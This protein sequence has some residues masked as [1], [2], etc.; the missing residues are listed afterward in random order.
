M[1]DK[2]VS[3]QDAQAH[4]QDLL[5]F[6]RQGH[7]VLIAEGDDVFARIAP[8]A[9]R[10]RILGLSRGLIKMSDDFDDPLPDSFWFGEE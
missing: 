9:R 5:E 6:V 3:P 4:L 2:I 8:V 7:E 1:S 10:K